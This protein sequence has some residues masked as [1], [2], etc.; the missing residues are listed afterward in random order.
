MASK[1]YDTIRTMAGKS[2]RAV[3]AAAGRG[4]RFL[5][6]TKAYPKE[7]VPILDKPNIQYL[8]EELLGAGIKEIAIVHRPGNQQVKDY[9]LPDPD[10]EKYLQENHKED[11]LAGWQKLY[12]KAKLSFIP[13]KKNLPYGSAAALLS[14]QSFVKNHPFI[15]LYGDDLVVE[16][17]SGQFLASLIRLFEKERADII[18]AASPVPWKE[19]ERY[20]SI[21]YK[22]K[23]KKHQIN[24]VFEKLPRQQAPSNTTLFGRFVAAPHVFNFLKKQKISA[25]GELFFTDTVNAIAQKGVV[26]APPLKNGQWL[27]T[28]DPLRWLKANIAIGLKDPEIEKE[29]RSFLKTI[30]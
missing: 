12:K 13:Q 23:G 15:F 17:K 14:A 5:P 24:K 28:G 21:Q 3:I 25:K 26:L 30:L 4:T 18:A 11:F 8:I 19:I 1:N 29:L 9:F 20:S 27:T 10:L 2:Y 22:R 6:A 16:K 7:L